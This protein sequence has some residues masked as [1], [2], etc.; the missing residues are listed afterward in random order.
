M[1]KIRCYVRSSN[2]IINGMY[3]E[4][5]S[6]NGRHA[7]L[8]YEEPVVPLKRQV[9]LIYKDLEKF[10]RTRRGPCWRLEVSQDYPTFFGEGSRL[11]KNLYLIII[12][13]AFRWAFVDGA[14][15]WGS[16]KSK[17][18]NRLYGYS[19]ESSFGKSKTFP[20]NHKPT[21]DS[22]LPPSGPYETYFWCKED[23]KFKTEVTIDLQGFYTIFVSNSCNLL[24]R[25]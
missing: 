19:T 12:V 24:R 20:Q 16:K 15:L 4:K 11:V 9:W 2:D 17:K 18:N 5:D 22:Y 25:S 21:S 14:Y 23:E 10:D 1:S 8:K 7:F 3:V 13:T 6:Y